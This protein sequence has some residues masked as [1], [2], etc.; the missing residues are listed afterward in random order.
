M[1]SS[2]SDELAHYERLYLARKRQAHADG[3]CGGSR[4]CPYCLYEKETGTGRF[5]TPHTPPPA[6]ETTRSDS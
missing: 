5:A 1:T 3:E 6:P 4:T 2:M